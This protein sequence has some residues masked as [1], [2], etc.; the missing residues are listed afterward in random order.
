[1]A[2]PTRAL[3]PG[4]QGSGLWMGGCGLQHGPACLARRFEL[5]SLQVELGSVEMKLLTEPL[6]PHTER[7]EQVLVAEVE[8]LLGQA[9]DTRPSLGLLGY[10]GSWVTTV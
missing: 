8:R 4:H 10:G 5:A 9:L 1:V 6:W 3:D 7:P 2:Q